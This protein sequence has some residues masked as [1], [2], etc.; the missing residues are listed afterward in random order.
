MSDQDDADAHKLSEVLAQ[1]MTDA[2][3]GVF[4]DDLLYLVERRLRDAQAIQLDD[5][6]LFVRA[7]EHAVPTLWHPAVDQEEHH[8]DQSQRE[9]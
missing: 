5:G 6:T 3:L 7:T 8:V 4:V 2:R 9:S 1:A